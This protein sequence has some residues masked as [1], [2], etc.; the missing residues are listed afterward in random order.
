MTNIITH[1]PR[2]WSSQQRSQE[3]GSIPSRYLR[4]QSHRLIKLSSWT[5]G[6]LYSLK[7][8]VGFVSQYGSTIYVA[9]SSNIVHFMIDS[10]SW[11][12]GTSS[13][14]DMLWVRTYSSVQKAWTYTI[15]VIYKRYQCFHFPSAMYPARAVIL[16]FRDGEHQWL[17][18]SDWSK[19]P[20]VI[21]PSHD[22][23]S[24]LA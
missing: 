21:E 11:S 14:N 2:Q 10:T 5:F 9:S 16:Y 23:P 8:T 12:V 15:A 6:E 22:I 13:W 19:S 20:S 7:R 3:H 24:P 1:T 17:A 4:D 18:L